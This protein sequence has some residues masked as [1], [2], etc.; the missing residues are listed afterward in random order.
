MKYLLRNIIRM[1]KRSILLF[2]MVLLVMLLSSFGVFVNKLCKEAEAR[3]F[4]P[5]YGYY[6]VADKD[7]NAFLGYSQMRDLDE[8]S[9]AITDVAAV[10]RLKCM[11]TDT[12]FYGTGNYITTKSYKSMVTFRYI[13]ETGEFV[14]GFSLVGVNSTDICE[15]FYNGTTVITK[16]SGISDNDNE[17]GVY[18]VV[19]SDK[20]AEL[21][22][23]SLGDG[24]EINV[25]SLIMGYEYAKYIVE[26][27][28]E[29]RIESMIG[30]P[31]PDDRFVSFTVG[32]IYHTYTNNS[33]GCTEPCDDTSN[34]LYVPI[35]TVDYILSLYEST[36]NNVL[37]K[38]T[39][40]IN[41]NMAEYDYAAV[42]GILDKAY[43]R[44][45]PH[46]D[47]GALEE[48][49]NEIGYYTTVRL[50]PFTSDS[51]GLPSSRIFRIV[52]FAL[53]IVA[54]A[55]FSIL[56]LIII[57]GITSRKREFN[58]LVALGKSRTRVAMSYLGE[59]TVM[60]LSAFFVAAV[61]FGLLVYL[62]GGSISA[63]LDAADASVTYA[64]EN[65]A[66]VLTDSMIM[67]VRNETM[68]DFSRLNVSYIL[69]TFIVTAAATALSLLAMAVIVTVMIK[70]INALRAMGEGK[71]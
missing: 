64:N 12:D 30:F 20:V 33:A 51:V 15:D 19:I 14:R 6:R 67:A 13:D 21:N 37:C 69:P 27:W 38:E 35:S 29:D 2:S 55:G 23:Y 65:S 61:C 54:A 44:L 53:Y 48:K 16:G 8:Q 41:A 40:M 60:I 36:E 17:N 58:C 50:I 39:A 56:I 62:S 3:S 10:V 7:G 71:L 43:V 28:P 45:A 49:I 26:G 4:G 1:P 5:L 18:K 46:T 57:F 31:V 47:S 24:I 42:A 63:Y 66:S 34:R 68:L 22:G 32:G 70:R 59:I 25:W 52:S 11:S 9:P